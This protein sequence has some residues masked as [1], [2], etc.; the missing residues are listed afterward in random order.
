MSGPVRL[1]PDPARVPGYAHLTF[2]I[3]GRDRIII[4]NNL[5]NEKR[6]V[7]KIQIIFNVLIKINFGIVH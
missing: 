4:K 7:M 2:I 6:S 1:R 5:F 3:V